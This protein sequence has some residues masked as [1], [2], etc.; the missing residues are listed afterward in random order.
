MKQELDPRYQ[1]VLKRVE[2]YCLDHENPDNVTRYAHYFREGYDAFG[3]TEEEVHTLRDE[4]V[5]TLDFSPEETAELAW[6][7]FQPGKYE[8]GTIAILLLKEK[9]EQF[10]REIFAWVKRCFDKGVENWAHSDML[11]S[12]ITPVFLDKEI[13]ELNDFDDWRTSESKWTRRAVPVTMLTLKSTAEPQELLDYLDPMMMDDERVVHQGLG[14]FLRE[15]WKLHHEPVEEFLA[16]HKDSCAR[17]IIQYAT[18]K[19]RSDTKENFRRSKNHK[20]QQDKPR[21]QHQNTPFKPRNDKPEAKTHGPRKPLPNKHRLE[22]KVTPP[23]KKKKLK[24]NKVD[25]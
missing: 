8:Y 15:L 3:L 25:A 12:N 4:L 1:K 9:K 22:P 2:G 6:H 24:P 16:K 11:C 23:P 19:M 10:N 7:L 20:P 17:L 21:N 18:E 5:D 13:V 14:W